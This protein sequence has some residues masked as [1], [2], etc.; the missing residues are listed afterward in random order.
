MCDF[1]LEW[2]KERVVAEKD[3]SESRDLKVGKGAAGA[4]GRVP[5]RYQHFTFHHHAESGSS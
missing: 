5:T 3:R 2:V 1:R 4:Q